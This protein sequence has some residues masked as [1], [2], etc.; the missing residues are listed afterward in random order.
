MVSFNQEDLD[1]LDK[2]VIVEGG[3]GHCLIWSLAIRDI[4]SDDPSSQAAK[5]LLVAAKNRFEIHWKK[6]R[7]R[8]V[9]RRGALLNYISILHG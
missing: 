9:L 6:D 3:M 5:T 4:I 1:T 8:R 7:T 2:G